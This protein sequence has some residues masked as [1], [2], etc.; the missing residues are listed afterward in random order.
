[1][2]LLQV[3]MSW[4][5]CNVLSVAVLQLELRERVVLVG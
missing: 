3:F 2:K 4:G 1:M 5:L